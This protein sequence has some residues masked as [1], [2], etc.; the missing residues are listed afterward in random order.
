MQKSKVEEYILDSMEAQERVTPPSPSVSSG[1]RWTKARSFL[2]PVPLAPMQ[3]SPGSAKISRNY[4][5][6]KEWG[7]VISCSKDPSSSGEVG[8]GEGKCKTFEG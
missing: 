4:S 7:S 2:Y 1:I 3:E 5:L 8:A 6:N